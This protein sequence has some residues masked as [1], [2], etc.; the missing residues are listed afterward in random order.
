MLREYTG[1]ITTD[2]SGNVTTYVEGV[3]TGR[4]QAIKI[5]IG[6]SSSLPCT[7]TGEDTGV[8]ILTETFTANKWVYPFAAGSKVADGTDS[9][10]SE[11][12]VYLYRERIKVVV[13]SGT[14][15]KVSTITVYVDEEG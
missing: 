8:A 7:I 5:G 2:G 12:P 6:T 13:A 10:I 9:T 15:S 3:I 14:T 4:I 11:S 1:T